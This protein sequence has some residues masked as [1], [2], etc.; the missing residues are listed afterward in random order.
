MC[1][2]EIELRA[3]N[4]LTILVLMFNMIEGPIW[5][6]NEHKNIHFDNE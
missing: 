4:M 1:L 5:P 6:L 3:Q 2:E